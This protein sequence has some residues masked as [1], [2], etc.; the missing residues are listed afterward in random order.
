M[1]PEKC[2]F[3]VLATKFMAFFVHKKGIEVDN[4]KTKVVL[5]AVCSSNEAEYE[6]LIVGLEVLLDMKVRSVHIY[7]DS[8]LVI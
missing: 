1:N 4:K 5:E 7:R 6:A 3:G 2:G 8:Q